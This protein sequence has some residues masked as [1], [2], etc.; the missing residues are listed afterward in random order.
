MFRASV[1]IL[2]DNNRD[3]MTEREKVCKVIDTYLSSFG[4]SW[5]LRILYELYYG[6]KRFNELKRLLSPITQAVLSRHLKNLEEADLIE[7]TET[8]KAVFYTIS[9]DGYTVV[10]WMISTYNWLIEHHP[11]LK[12][13]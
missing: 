6:P 9:K 3:G 12:E 8:D 2:S 11:D 1:F 4:N 5:N 10:P 13:M 7:R